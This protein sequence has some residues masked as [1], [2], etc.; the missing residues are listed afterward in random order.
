MA[1]TAISNTPRRSG[2]DAPRRHISA[3]LS[4]DERWVLEQSGWGTFEWDTE[5]D[6]ERAISEGRLPNGAFIPPQLLV[7]FPS[8]VAEEIEPAGDAEAGSP[9][10]VVKEEV[11]DENR[12]AVEDMSPPFGDDFDFISFLAQQLQDPTVPPSGQTNS[13][14]LSLSSE[15]ALPPAPT[16]FVNPPAPSSFSSLLPP[17]F[18]QAHLSP[19]FPGPSSAAR[20]PFVTP[21]MTRRNWD[22]RSSAQTPDLSPSGSSTSSE[23]DS[24]REQELEANFGV[25]AYPYPPTSAIARSSKFPTSYPTMQPECA[26]PAPAY[27]YS[28]F[29]FDGG[30]PDNLGAIPQTYF[31]SSQPPVAGPSNFNTTMHELPAPTYTPSFADFE[32]NLD[33]NILSA[34]LEHANAIGPTRTPASSTRIAGASASATPYGRKG[35]SGASAGPS[36]PP[37]RARAR[38]AASDEGP[39]E[40]DPR[41]FGKKA[42]LRCP[43]CNYVQKRGAG[44]ARSFK[45]HLQTHPE[46]KNLEWWCRGIMGEFAFLTSSIS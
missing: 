23:V 36:R 38:R 5:P 4:D 13:L 33:P 35:R 40:F 32:L 19:A 7:Q 8:P 43:H 20:N 22:L 16:R 24:D 42:E 45:R 30:Y 17:S 6:D 26:F 15:P 1:L 9:F 39:L 27:P 29:E 25:P 31:P 21:A 2:Q 41:S 37:R 11:I 10:G 46:N 3:R 28:Q 34:F 18:P 12:I 44:E 14:Q